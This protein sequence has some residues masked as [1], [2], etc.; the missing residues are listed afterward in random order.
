MQKENN[1]IDSFQLENGMWVPS[2]QGRLFCSRRDP[3]KEAETWCR[4]VEASYQS[5]KA[6]LIL[7]LGAGFHIVTLPPREKVFVLELRQDLIEMFSIRNPEFSSQVQFISPETEWDATVLEFRPAWLGLEKEYS[8]YSRYFRG[9]SPSALK[10]QAEK[11]DLW[12]LAQ[13]LDDSEN[14]PNMEL[15]VKDI[16]DLFPGENQTEE[17]KLW[18]TLKEFVA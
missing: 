5:A 16:A 15:T 6:V 18:R 12:M 13:V 3:V 9:V 1:Q 17:A 7:G 10:D 14:L 4:Q 11:R 8:F 2:L